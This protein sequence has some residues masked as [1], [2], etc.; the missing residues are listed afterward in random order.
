MSWHKIL[1]LL[2]VIAAIHLVVIFGC[3][4]G[5]SDV[6]PPDPYAEARE[7][8][9]ER[10]FASGGSG[11]SGSAV[12]G[13]RPWDYSCKL[14]LPDALAQKAQKASGVIVVELDSRR[15][16]WEK[17]SRNPVAIASLTKLMTALLVAEKLENDPQFKLDEVITLSSTATGVESHKFNAGTRLTV[18]DLIL[19]MMIASAND[20]ATSLAERIGGTVPEFVEMMNR[21]AAQMGLEA[22]R[23]NSPSGLP[24]GRERENSYASVSDILHLCE[25]LMKYRVIMDACG[26]SYAKLS[27]DYPVYTTNGLLLHP[28]PNRPYY[29]KVPGLIGFKTGFTNAAKCCLAFGVIRND[30]IIIGCVTGF[31][32]AADRERFCSELIEWAFT[33]LQE[34]N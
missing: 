18:H 25:A 4:S 10:L 28:R 15:V 29:R 2:A 17:N 5:G 13:V 21:R 31:P 27:N 26:E 24:Q 20:A 6:P 3:M 11:T 16:L 9:F 23:F 19:A 1:I 12:S 14:D 33:V 8:F 32:S 22:A 30:R 7:T 34:S